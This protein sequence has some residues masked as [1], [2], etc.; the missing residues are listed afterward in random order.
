MYHNLIY[1]KKKKVFLGEASVNGR[2]PAETI[3]RV[4]VRASGSLS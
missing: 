3:A 1:I 2:R 4:Q